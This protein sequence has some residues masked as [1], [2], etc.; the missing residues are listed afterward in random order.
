MIENTE[1]EKS[2]VKGIS[3]LITCVECG[4]VEEVCVPDD[5]GLPKKWFWECDACRV[6]DDGWVVRRN[7]EPESKRSH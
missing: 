3:V 7:G 5:R 4:T 2:A 6:H 1:I